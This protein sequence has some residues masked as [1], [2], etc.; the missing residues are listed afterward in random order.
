MKKNK[1]I[2]ILISIIIIFDFNYFILNFILL[3]KK[4]FACGIYLWWNFYTFFYRSNY[5]F[6]YFRNYYNFFGKQKSITF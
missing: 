1:K 3:Y 4:R 6:I 2:I 5:S